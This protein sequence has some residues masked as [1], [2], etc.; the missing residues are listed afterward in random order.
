M[1]SHHLKLIYLKKVN[2]YT[3]ICIRNFQFF[4]LRGHFNDK[5]SGIF[6]LQQMISFSKSKVSIGFRKFLE[7]YIRK[8]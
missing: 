8:R 7:K 2:N 4:F 6:L 3:K 5:Q 1:N